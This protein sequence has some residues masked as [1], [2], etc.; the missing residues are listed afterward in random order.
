MNL[1]TTAS[2]VTLLLCLV[3][4]GCFGRPDS[5]VTDGNAN[6]PTPTPTPA[7]AEVKVTSPAKDS[8]VS[9]SEMVS[10]TSRNVPAG[11]KIWVVVYVHDV[12]RYYPQNDAAVVQPDGAWNSPA[13]FGVPRDRGLKF[14]ALAV[15]VDAAAEGAFRSY[16]KGATDRN[17]FPGLPQLPPGATQRDRVTVTR[18]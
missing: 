10:G 14:D 3:A 15:T 16:L 9:M 6:Q 13:S 12:R 17:D 2:G 4:A 18:R 8:T 1:R 11:E 7:A 5:N